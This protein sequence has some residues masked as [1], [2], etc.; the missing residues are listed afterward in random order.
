MV[1]E[2]VSDI[3]YF[4]RW[5]TE[6]L[7]IA[8]SGRIAESASFSRVGITQKSWT[9]NFS[10]LFFGK[11]WIQGVLVLSLIPMLHQRFVDSF[12]LTYMADSMQQC[13]RMATIIT[14]ILSS[15]PS[16]APKEHT[17]PIHHIQF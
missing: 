4:Y 17:Y 14:L 8:R 1:S 2:A 3:L 12:I 5:S 11:N 13:P 9:K 6:S 7:T 16:L 15:R 10:E